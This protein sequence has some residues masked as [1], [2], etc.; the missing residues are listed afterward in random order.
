M[1]RSPHA[2]KEAVILRGK[3]ENSLSKYNAGI[4]VCLQQQIHFSY[5]LNF[6]VVMLLPNVS[7][8]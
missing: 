6:Q 3:K 8:L 4:A 7:L 2:L 5:V 1:I